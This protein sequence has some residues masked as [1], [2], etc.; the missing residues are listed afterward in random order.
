MY[1]PF[2]VSR[3]KDKLQSVIHPL[4]NQTSVM[5]RMNHTPEVPSC[6]G[7][8]I[9]HHLHTHHPP[10]SFSSWRSNISCPTTQHQRNGG[11]KHPL[12]G[13]I[14]LQRR[15]HH[16]VEACVQL[17]HHQNCWVEKWE[18]YQHIHSLQGQSDHFW[19][20]LYTASERGHERCRLLFYHCNRGAWNQHLRHHHSQRLWYK[21]DESS[22][23]YLVF[24]H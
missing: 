14:L 17:G 16:W 6:P 11:T 19:K 12:V 8:L 3:R 10:L 1:I 23:L 9:Q 5:G 20:W 24:K 22:W 21:L 4:L 13:W 7:Q 18:L 2:M 15:R